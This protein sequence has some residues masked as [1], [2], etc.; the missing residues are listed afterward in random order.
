MQLIDKKCTTKIQHCT[1]STFFL[2][3]IKEIL[4]NIKNLLKNN[5]LKRIIFNEIQILCRDVIIISWIKIMS[6][7]KNN[8]IFHRLTFNKIII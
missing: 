4:S 8:F 3:G 5:C 1:R 7:C 2:N 6:K